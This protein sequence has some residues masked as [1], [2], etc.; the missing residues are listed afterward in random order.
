MISFR[1][2]PQL[3]ALLLV[4]AAPLTQGADKTAAMTIP[5]IISGN[6]LVE[7]H[8]APPADSKLV[9]QLTEKASADAKPKVL[10]EQQLKPDAQ[11]PTPYRLDYDAVLINPR[12]HYQVSARLVA[13]GK[14][15]FAAEPA[16]VITAGSPG[17]VD[18]LLKKPG[19]AK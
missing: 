2:I 10:A 18:L 15:L 16:P 12:Y 8:G 1:I 6:L 5:A 17:H 14:T 19:T 9:V 7:Q 11:A 3:F 13:G 4:L